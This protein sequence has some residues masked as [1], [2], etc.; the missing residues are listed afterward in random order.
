MI[1]IRDNITHEPFEGVDVGDIGPK[2]GLP[3]ADN[4]YIKFSNYRVAKKFMLTRFSRINDQGEYE[5][6]DP[7]ALKVM[8]LMLMYAR[9][10]IVLDS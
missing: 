9:L 8:H 10:M 3:A 2:L 7:N 6:L 1:P 5:I 4:A